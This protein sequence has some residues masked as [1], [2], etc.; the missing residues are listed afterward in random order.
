MS[1]DHYDS[2]QKQ[3][4]P[5]NLL[6]QKNLFWIVTAV[7][8]DAG[9]SKQKFTKYIPLFEMPYFQKRMKVIVIFGLKILTN[10]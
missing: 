5:K 7:F 4:V 10:Y 9:S 3:M 8:N 1:T 6:C 2:K